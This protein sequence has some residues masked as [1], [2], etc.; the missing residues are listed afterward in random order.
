[1]LASPS[2]SSPSPRLTS[3]DALRGFDMF[4]IVGAGDLVHGL[5]KIS[6]E[7]ILGAL[8][9]Q[10]HH[11]AWAKLFVGGP[12]GATFGPYAELVLVLTTLGFGF[13]FL[14]FLYHRKISLR[15]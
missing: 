15:V 4:W 3:L 7:G 12:I 14:R 5:E 9:G 6:S 10:L 8:A 13:W 11:K 2:K 1:M